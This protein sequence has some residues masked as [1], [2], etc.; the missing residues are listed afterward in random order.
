MTVF[1]REASKLLT[2][3]HGDV[4]SR[5][6]KV[7]AGVAGLHMLHQQL[8]VYENIIKDLANT[9]K[10]NINTTQK[11]INR[12][13]TPVIER[14]MTAAYDACVAE[15]GMYLSSFRRIDLTTTGPGSFVRMKAAMQ[16][17]VDQERHV[18]FQQS[19]DEAKR[20]LMEMVE[21]ASETMSDRMD[22]VFVAMR[23]DYRSVL[24]GGDTQGEVLPKSQRLLRK[25]VMITLDGVE[26]LFKTALGQTTEDD[27]WNAEGAVKKSE[28][29]EA[30]HDFDMD[31]AFLQQ[32]LAANNETN[33]QVK[34]EEGERKNA[35]MDDIP[36]SASR[37]E[38]DPMPHN[39]VST[40]DNPQLS[41]D[42]LPAA[43]EQEDLKMEPIPASTKQEKVKPESIFKHHE[44]AHMSRSAPDQ[45][46]PQEQ[47][48]Q[49]ASNSDEEKDESYSA[50]THEDDKENQEDHF[51]FERD[52]EPEHDEEMDSFES[53]PHTCY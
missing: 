10:G 40:N 25:Q 46:E 31:N 52:G 35:P 2:E 16:D 36:G 34:S 27:D 14:A 8:T 49:I 28:E 15:A 45:P 48:T 41:G 22:E 5:A 18:M 9:I 23:R 50:G 3:F 43:T 6:S 4:N 44:D 30:K 13:F 47:E 19:A 53:F 20:R 12:E 17:H 33:R 32:D 51:P 29:C 21:Q 37:S 24:G 38:E 26:R 11:D 7:G 42:H 1:T 39:R